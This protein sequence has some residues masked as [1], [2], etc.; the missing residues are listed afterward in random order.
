MISIRKVQPD[1]ESFIYATWLRSQYYGYTF[2][3]RVE[4]RTFF[5]HYKETIRARLLTSNVNVVCLESD[6]DVVLGYCVY[7]KDGTT[8]HW[9]YVKRAWREQGI[10]KACLPKSIRQISSLTNKGELLFKLLPFNPFY[11]ETP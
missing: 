2:F 7:S 4:K 9:A 8:L 6:P 10:M 5:N 3:K 1:D 11:K